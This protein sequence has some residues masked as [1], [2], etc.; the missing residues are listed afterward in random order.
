MRG[1]AQNISIGFGDW[2][3]MVDFAL[4]GRF[5]VLVRPLELLCSVLACIYNTSRPVI[6]PPPNVRRNVVATLFLHVL[7][8]R[9]VLG[10]SSPGEND[11]TLGR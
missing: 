2:E 5:D 1:E 7:I 8:M 10:E 4:L 3:G 6:N 9:V 11:N